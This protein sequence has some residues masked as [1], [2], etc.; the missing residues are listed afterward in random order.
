M[1]HITTDRLTD[2]WKKLNEAQ[3]RINEKSLPKL[4]MNNI[5]LAV[6]KCHKSAYSMNLLDVF[7]SINGN[8]IR[9]DVA[10]LNNKE[11]PDLDEVS[12]ILERVRQ[13]YRDMKDVIEEE[14]HQRLRNSDDDVY[15][16]STPDD[17]M[18]TAKFRSYKKY[19]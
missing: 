7:Y 1:G 5:N 9:D 15:D 17:R 2:G 14:L 19:Y 18:P 4:A 16:K 3:Y 10:I 6:Q 13:L 12:E 11:E 8:E